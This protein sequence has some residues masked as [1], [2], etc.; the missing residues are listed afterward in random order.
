MNIEINGSQIRES[1]DP[2]KAAGQI[3]MAAD[4]RAQNVAPDKNG[5]ITIRI[6]AVGA[7]DAILQGLEV[8]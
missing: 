6:T 4:L 5:K 1:W 7:N 8:E 2:A 3:G